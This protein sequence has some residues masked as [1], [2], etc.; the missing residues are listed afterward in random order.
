M[1]LLKYILGFRKFS[2]IVDIKNYINSKLVTDIEENVIKSK[3]LLLFDTS[4]Q[5]TWIIFSNY[6]LYC[7]L[8]DISKDTFVVRWNIN[9]NEI[10]K[11]S[12]VILDIKIHE[13]YS[14]HSGLVDFGRK[15]KDWLYSKKLFPNSEILMRTLKSSILQSMKGNI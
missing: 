7:V 1:S 2:T 12:E 13:N 6:K 14:E 11:G 10:I 3:H 15:H 8:D 9:K 4:K 5:K